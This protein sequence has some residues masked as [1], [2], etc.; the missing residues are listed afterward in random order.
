MF[1]FCL[2]YYFAKNKIRI[3]FNLGSSNVTET[4]ATYRISSGIVRKGRKRHDQE[5]SWCLPSKTSK[6]N[7]FSW[8]LV[9]GHLHLQCVSGVSQILC[10]EHCALLTNQKSSLVSLLASIRLRVT[11]SLTLKVL[12]PTLSGQIDKSQTLSPLTPCTFKRSSTT[13][14]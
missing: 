9:S 6:I 7:E 5:I 1:V 13:P 3:D 8:S 14:P 2:A 4:K 10:S 11:K 12:Q